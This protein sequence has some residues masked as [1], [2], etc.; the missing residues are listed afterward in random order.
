MDS[1]YFDLFHPPENVICVDLDTNTLSWKH[2]RNDFSI[3]IL[4]KKP[5]STLQNHLRSI[6]N[7]LKENPRILEG[8]PKLKK[9]R[10]QFDLSIREAFLK[11]MIS[12]LHNYKQFLRMV[13]RRPD[14]KAIDRNLTT[15]FDCEG[16]FLLFFN[17][18]NND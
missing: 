8:D 14:I 6:Y 2:D 5:L 13:T 12:I 7:S 10:R 1:R 15:F 9:A 4:P 17:N 3:K 18:F 11:F 16:L